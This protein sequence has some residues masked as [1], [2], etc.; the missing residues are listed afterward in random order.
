MLRSLLLLSLTTAHLCAGQS[1]VSVD[2][3]TRYQ[4]LDPA[5]RSFRILYEV[6]SAT[7]G[8]THYYNTLRKGSE[9]QVSA[10]TDVATGKSLAWTIVS[11]PDAKKSG[12]AEAEEDTDYI[13]VQLARPVPKGGEY[14]L[15]IDKTYKD[16]ASYF[17]QGDHIVFAR[18][19]SITRNSVVLPPN[20]ELT[21]CNT[22]VQVIQETDGRLLVSFINT[23]SGSI[24]FRLE[25]RKLGRL[26]SSYRTP[27]GPDSET[28]GSGRDKSRA[29]VS[30]QIPERAHQTREIVYFLQQPETHSFR[31]YHDY[32]ESRPGIDRYLNVVR[33][34]SKASNPSARDL[35]TGKELE[36]ETL[37]GEQI[38]Q[39][40]IDIGERVNPETEVVIIWFDPV[41]AGET[42]RI[43]IEETYSDPK[44]YLISGNE[45]VWDRAF[46]RVF[47]EV[48][49]PE[50]WLLT[51]SSIPAKVSTEPDGKVR[52]SFVNARPDEID[53]FI[54]G[55]KR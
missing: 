37:N 44:R 10:V 33:A 9:H 53:V 15:L 32:T 13:K 43:R 54:K 41:K 16:S 28:M 3:Y 36:V 34:G 45:F 50:G 1:Q 23:Q 5:T 39:R 46:G 22:P 49:F 21:Y 14:R 42:M 40:K 47:N 17:T 6:T 20:Y 8:A 24:N 19:L 2:S 7:E 55:Q 31:L 52:L 51:H 18:S 26:L 48:I 35:D 12:F 38:T 30:Y 11:G 25:A 4:L 27:P 29:R